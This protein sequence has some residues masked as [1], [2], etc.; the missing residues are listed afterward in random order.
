[1]KA[2]SY[3][4][5]S[6][7]EQEETGYSLPAQEKLL[8]EYAQ[9][10]SLEVVKVFSVA[11]SAS[12]AKQRQV[13]GEMMEFIK[14]RNIPHLLTEKVDRITRNLKEAVVVNDWVEGDESRQIHFVKQN[15]IV[16]KNSKS[17]DQFRWDIEI[18]LAKKHISNL[19]EEV[20][21]GQKEK[22]SQ[23]WLPTKPPLGYR[24]VGDK[25]H[26][27]HV[28]NE[29]KDSF[30][31]EMFELYSTGNYSL[32]ALVGEMFKRG[33]RNNAGNKVGKSRMHALL[34][35][36]FY[37]G[38]MRWKGVVTKGNHPPIVSKN[39]FERVQFLLG[40]KI[41]SPQYRKHTPVFKA[42]LNCAECKGTITWEIQKG[43]W[44]GHCNHYKNCSQKASI[45]QDRLEE[46]L[47]PFFDGVA[48]K[49]KKVLDW[50][51][52]ALKE[53]HSEEIEQHTK[54]RQDI[55]RGIER[56]DQRMERAYLDK[57]DGAIDPALCQK[58]ME[59]SKKEKAALV[60]ALNALG[61][62]QTAYY[63]AGFAI[64]E[65]AANARAI[66]ESPK[67]TIEEKRLLLSH[68][69]SNIELKQG[70]ST[71][72]YTYAFEF[73]S[74][75]VP[76]LNESFELEESQSRQGYSV[77]SHPVSLTLLREQ[78]SNLQPTP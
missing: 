31:K 65:L 29:E 42:K 37:Y 18:V 47:F 73:L 70:T 27:I 75:W 60:E 68:V 35:D 56:A 17:D 76:K 12:G 6:S 32:K 36:P 58:I 74:E 26:K 8:M 41:G 13:F 57:L 24:T 43:N 59:D 45:R 25:G 53:S 15:L 62:D 66:Y 40:R 39:L 77:P 49:S 9:R 71:P 2:V 14:K 50:L 3:A 67:A 51:E 55:A 28:I 46:E 22:I 61:A 38:D 1:M 63:D 5:V 52:R 20:K 16:H 33:L 48:P 34:T 54:R 11:E 78:D 23:G 64:H 69:F 72:N 30:I 19:S 44:Y 4:R 21:K 7:R 10:R